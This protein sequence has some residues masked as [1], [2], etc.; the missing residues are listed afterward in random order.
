VTLFPR[1]AL[2]SVGVAPLTSMYFQGENDRHPTDDFRPEYHDS[3]GLMIHTGAGE[4]IWRPIRN[5]PRKLVSFF[6][7]NN[8]RGFGLMQRDRSFESYQDLEAFYHRRPG[9]WVEPIG[10]WG[11]G[12]IEL[13]EIPT[14]NETHDNVV[15]YWTP[16][17]PY[18]PGQEVAFGYRLVAVASTEDMHPGGKVVN[19]FQTPAR[20]SG[21]AEPS[22]PTLRRFLI[23][24]AGGDLEFY[25]G[26]PQMVSIFW[27]W[28]VGI[29]NVRIS[30]ELPASTYC[31]AER[32][33]QGCVA[34]LS[35]SGTPSARAASAGERRSGPP[36]CMIC[37]AMESPTASSAAMPPEP[38][39]FSMPCA[40]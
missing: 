5:P 7:D 31:A 37:C 28:Q 13:V 22:D 21:S 1:R 24:F 29:D 34:L 12:R 4:W 17:Q 11:E 26:D 36:A 38:L 14:A 23:D 18:E 10:Q 2:T 39:P 27:F 30:N 20:A 40:I 35:L 19:T 9:Y 16:K 15:A 33:S 32:T 8:P 25:Y 3:D 6:S